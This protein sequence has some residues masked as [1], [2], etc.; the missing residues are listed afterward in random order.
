MGTS[1]R[2]SSLAEVSFSIFSEILA[3]LYHF[4][5]MSRPRVNRILKTRDDSF[6]FFLPTLSRGWRQEGVEEMMRMVWPA[7]PG[8][9]EEG[10]KMLAGQAAPAGG[11][12]HSWCLWGEGYHVIAL[13]QWRRAQGRGQPASSLDD[14]KITD[15]KPRSGSSWPLG[16]LDAS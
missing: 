9:G 11:S 14:S 4:P 5:V 12:G 1:S 2:F 13:V 8:H 15:L 7:D 10:L 16:S 6:F 3:F